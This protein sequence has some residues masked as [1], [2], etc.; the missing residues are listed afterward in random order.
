MNERANMLCYSNDYLPAVVFDCRILHWGSYMSS[1]REP[2]RAYSANH[3]AHPCC[4]SHRTKLRKTT[5][6]QTCVYFNNE[7]KREPVL[8]E[9]Q[10][11]YCWPPYKAQV[12][13]WSPYSVCAESITQNKHAD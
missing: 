10:G 4:N 7:P 6:S 1:G 11:F 9:I 2:H 13:W 8:I 3:S 5:V 12:D